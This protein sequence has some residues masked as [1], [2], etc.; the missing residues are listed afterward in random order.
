MIIV[1][2]ANATPEN[3]ERVVEEIKNLGYQSHVIYGQ[4]CNVIGAVGDEREKHRLQSLEA[5]E[6]VE[7]VVP[8]LEPFKLAG[9]EIRP[10]YSTI[11]INNQVAIGGKRFIV[12]AGP[13]S[14]ESCEQ[15]VDAA[16][17]VAKLGA[18]ILRGGA[19]K[20]RTSPYSFQG[21]E[22]E[23]LKYLKKASKITGLPVITEVMNPRDIEL[24]CQYADIIQIGARNMQNFSLLKEVGAIK[25]P[26]FL[27]NF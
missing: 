25:K 18:H 14:V 2:Q 7:K 24:I 15:I 26:V 20:P 1:M 12:M 9:R 10:E 22:E 17:V 6:G 19:F 23:G 11:Q 5:L 4:K 21:L 13:C 8:I 16:K 27:K 3:L